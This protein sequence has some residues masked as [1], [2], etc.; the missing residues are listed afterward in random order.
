MA[1]SCAQLAL[2]LVGQSMIGE[3]Q[4][5]EQTDRPFAAI[6]CYRMQNSLFRAREKIQPLDIA[7]EVDSPP[8]KFPVVPCSSL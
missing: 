6:P 1:G 8:E 4:H 5:R 7:R 2:A 3:F